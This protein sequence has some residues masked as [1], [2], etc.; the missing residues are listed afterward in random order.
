MILKD[1]LKIYGDRTAGPA[2]L[3]GLFEDD[4]S[5]EAIF[6]LAKE[7]SDRPFSLVA[8]QSNDWSHDFSI[9]P[10]RSYDGSIYEGGGLETLA[11][12]KDIINDLNSKVYIAGYSLAGLFSLW[13]LYESD[14]FDGCI[15]CSGSLWYEGF[16][17]YVRD[18]H[19]QKEAFVYLSL[20]GKEEKTS[21]P[22]MAQIGIKTRSID[23]LL[24]DDERVLK[25]IL[26]MNPGGHF[27]SPEKRLAQGIA[28]IIENEQK[29]KAD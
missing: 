14:L 26:R 27:A 20:G 1:K 8:Y 23:R 19:C 2:I 4:D 11:S 22:L 17:E 21:N 5:A 13:S 28:W 12:L 25:H 16:E 6:N 9:W 18:R 3:L 10:A 24:D 7:N 29:T 15:C